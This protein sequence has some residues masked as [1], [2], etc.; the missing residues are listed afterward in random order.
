MI[1]EGLA[2]QWLRGW[3]SPNTVLPAPVPVGLVLPV[4]TGAST[5][6]GVLTDVAAG[7]VDEAAVVA[8]LTVDADIE[9][10]PTK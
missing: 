2:D 9:L 7:W 4:F 8:R 10:L 1:A 3:S 5:A 6:T